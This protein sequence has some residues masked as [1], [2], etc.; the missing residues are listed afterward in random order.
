MLTLSDGLGEGFRICRNAEIGQM[1]GS[2][3]DRYLLDVTAAHGTIWH[4][5]PARVLR[6]DVIRAAN[7]WIVPGWMHA[8]LGLHD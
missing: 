5:I 7:L 8:F 3:V 2:D 6:G 1:S 4:R